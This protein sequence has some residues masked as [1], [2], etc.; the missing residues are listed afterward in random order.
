VVTTDLKTNIIEDT[1]LYESVR[2]TVISARE[3]IYRTANFA[4]VEAYWKIGELIIKAQGGEERAEYGAGLIKVLAEKLTAEFGKG[5]TTTNLKTMRTFY[6]TFP[7]GAV[8]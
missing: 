7:K 2:N 8:A 3:K 4:M 5:F 1:N 6:I